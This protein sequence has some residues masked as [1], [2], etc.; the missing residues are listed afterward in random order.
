MGRADAVRDARVCLHYRQPPVIQRGLEPSSLRLQPDG[1]IVLVDFGIARVSDRQQAST[2]ARG[3]TPGPR[4][5]LK[6]PWFL[7]GLRICGG[8]GFAPTTTYTV[9]FSG[10]REFH[11][12]AS[13]GP[14]MHHPRWECPSTVPGGRQ[15]PHAYHPNNEIERLRPNDASLHNKRPGGPLF[16]LPSQ[17]A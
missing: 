17:R 1:T 4:S 16:P 14:S 6:N 15:T 12:P 9:L 7:R 11:H 3:L 5:V 2:G 8:W 10:Q 13:E